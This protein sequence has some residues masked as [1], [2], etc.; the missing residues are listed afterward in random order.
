[1][2]P[3]KKQFHTKHRESAWPCILH[4]NMTYVW[5][6][7]PHTNTNKEEEV[8]SAACEESQTHT[9]ALTSWQ[10]KR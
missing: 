9:E 3:G 6:S 8:S 1:M 4:T 2:L 7:S 10:S 5:L